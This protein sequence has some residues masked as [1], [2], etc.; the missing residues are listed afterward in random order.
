MKL[1]DLLKQFEGLDP[2][3]EIYRAT[4][5]DDD[6]D[7]YLSP[8]FYCKKLVAIKGPFEYLS[9]PSITDDLENVIEVWTIT[10]E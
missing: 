6:G 4:D 2:D 10:T 8:Y 3:T 5:M 7:A 9:I 1:K